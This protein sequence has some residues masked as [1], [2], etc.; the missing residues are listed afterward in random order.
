[1]E[2]REPV[3][4][5]LVKAW[6]SWGLV[7]LTIFPFIGALVSIKFHHPEFLSDYPWFTFGRL[8]PVHVNGVIFGAFSTSFIA[9]LYYLLPRLCGIPLYRE[10]WGRGLLWLWNIF[11]LAGSVS[12]LLGYNLGLEAAEFEWPMN[13][14]RFLVLGCLAIQVLGTVFRR[15]EPRLYVSLWYA[16]AALIWTIF[17]LIL[18]NAILPYSDISGTNSA[19]MHGL[20]IHYIVGLWLTPAG[21]AVI[22]YFLPLSVKQPLFSHKLSLLGFWSL[23]FFYPFVG[24]HHYLFSPIPYWTQTISIV[25]SMM[26]IIPVWTVTVNFFGTAKGQWGQFLG[27][28]HSDHYAAK[29]LILGAVYYL[30]GCF[31]GSVEALRRMQELTHF[32][33]FVI[34]HSHLTVFGSMVVWIVGGLYYVWPRITSRQLWSA[35][36]AS[37][38][39]WLTIVGF[40][41]MALGLTAQGFIQGTMLENG[42]SFVNSLESMKPWWVA[43]TLGGIAMDMA[44]GLMVLN[45]YQTVRKGLPYK[46]STMKQPHATPSFP[47][48]P[49]KRLNWLEAP[50]TI[51]IAGSIGFF[52]LAVSTQGIIPLVMAETRVTQVKETI[53][54]S[55]IEVSPY[56]KEELH[57]RQVYIREGCWYCHSQYI[58]PVTGEA[59]RWGPVSQVGEYAY[60]QP[61]L[62]STRR[63]GPDLTRIGRRYGDDWH[64]AHHWNPRALVPNSIM[65][66]FPWLFDS[67]KET[68]P[69]LNGDGQALITYLQ[70][71]GT[72]IG[73]WREGF[74]STRLAQGVPALHSPINKESVWETGHK[75]YQQHCQGC[76]GIHGDGQGPAASFLDPKPRDF[77]KG[78]FKFHSTAGQNSLPTDADLFAT[79]THGLWG[80]AMPPWYSLPEQKRLAVIQYIKTFSERWENE[81]VSEPVH[82]P[83]EPPVTRTALKEGASLFQ[84][85]CVVCHGKNGKGDGPL[86][87]KINDTW[88]HPIQPAN[89][90]LPAGIKGGV[91]LG[92]DSRHIF[93]TI[94]TGVGGDP[95]P[96][97]QQQLNEQEVWKVTHYV[98]SLRIRSQEDSLLAFG[99]DPDQLSESR[100]NLW[101]NLSKAAMGGK[102]DQDIL[103]E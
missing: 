98:Q 44:I 20:Y 69:V 50:S 72:S 77:T 23:A 89:F 12:L 14:L 42:V 38:H 15:R 18:G 93:I 92:H 39:L 40:T 25:M 28:D 11:L 34:A 88:G 56:S 3:N 27:G 74:V 17:N 35:R 49:A 95:M 48:L 7:W 82:V 58:R 64:T 94:M 68:T 2:T 29:F 43:R 30:L 41:I 33:D 54:N 71:L 46:D 70:R 1:M 5:D 85:H 78:I 63:I 52:F 96:A 55:T 86:A 100:K 62:F 9:L 91:K 99:L 4:H 21:L 79:I 65:P 59:L 22:Y 6:A 81:A 51:I 83:P 31:Q 66:R 24:T 53:T 103:N 16:M 60:D 97:F 10:Q 37:W 32:N 101:G 45:F 13:L 36:L 47:L 57:G 102:I 26:L 80:T 84:T 87:G 19:A 73:D 67:D 75:I 76:H 90:H 61:H 8:R